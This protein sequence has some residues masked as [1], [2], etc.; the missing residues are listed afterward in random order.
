MVRTLLLSGLVV[1]SLFSAT[2]SLYAQDLGDLVEA[3][4]N[5]E[6][7]KPSKDED[8]GSEKKGKGYAA[9]LK[10]ART[11]KGF[12]T[13]HLLDGKLYLEIPT[14]LI[15]KPMLFSGRVA[16]ISDNTDVIAGEMPSEPLMISWSKDDTKVY[17]HEVST[18]HLTDPESSIY[19]RVKDNNLDPVLN[20]FK[21]EAWKPDSSA[22]V[23]NATSL[24]L[25]DAKPMSPFLPKS[26][27]DALFGMK[28]MSGTFKK[29]LSSITDIS[30]FPN[31]FNVSIRA[32]YTV[33]KAPFTAIVNGSM[34]LLPDDVM[35]PRLADQRVGYFYNTTTRVTTDK[36]TMDKIK[37][38]NRWRLE[39][40]PEDLEAY[41]R[42]ELVVPQKQIVYYVDDAF[43]QEWYPY[44]KEGIEDWQKAFEEIGFRDAIIAKP[45]PKD[46]KFNPGDA[47]YS[48]I[49][50][51][52]S[53]QANAM[54][55]SW[56]DPRSGEILQSSVYFYHNV[57]RLLHSW[58]FVQTSAV[59][60]AARSLDYDLTVLGPMLRYLVAHEV[61]HT[62]G[63]MHNMGASYAYTP[64]EMRSPDFTAKWGTT[65]S[66]MDYARYNY[67][68]QPGDGVTYL[69]PPRLGVYDIYAIKW[70]YKPIF[71]AKTPQEELPTL[72][73]WIDEHKGDLRYAYGPQQILESGDY[74]AQTEDLTNDAIEASTLGV[75]NLKVTT[76][77]L[78]GWTEAKGDDYANQDRL[79]EEVR[80]QF[81]R[82]LGHVQSLIGGY[83][84]NLN[85][86]GD[87]QSKLTP[88][89]YDAQRNALFFIL[90]Q[91]L[92]FPY[93][94]ATPE[95]KEKLG[96]TEAHFADDMLSTMTLLV[97]NSVLGRLQR[98]SELMGNSRGR[99]YTAEMYLADLNAFV[100]QNTGRLT[101]VEKNMQYGYVSQLIDCLEIK[102][103]AK[104]K[105]KMNTLKVETK[106]SLWNALRYAESVAASRCTSGPDAGHYT[107][108][109]EMIREALRER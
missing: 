66:I 13:L 84:R 31:N 106:G 1:A 65:P 73:S 77:H 74:T 17:L 45:Y 70:G 100:W 56:T 109:Y 6:D 108:L 8:K 58:R 12:I 24:F 50:Y 10:G 61:G 107:A 53:H 42:G 38:I 97:N 83:R 87:G 60:P 79:L 90:K 93:W 16:G 94:I 32:V 64:K 52:S 72:R 48:C 88:A 55:P 101:P 54:G 104:T 68:A 33:D 103:D 81:R 29:D 9:L 39:P 19:N 22:V 3:V 86:Q 69:L 95:V 41:K 63:L 99:I 23:I 15:S 36:M 76:D 27:F 67:V 40:K 91:S 14:S 49:I 96:K 78:F 92:D 47:R 11:E 28:K 80:S 34:V 30:S 89:P 21:I 26:P 44:I 25:S 2:P 51:S 59:D 4:K 71:E 62:L 98:T 18:S 75:R 20:A 46:P 5:T 43:P 57:L 82:Y 35:R 105:G 102:K 37:Y 85:V 7:K